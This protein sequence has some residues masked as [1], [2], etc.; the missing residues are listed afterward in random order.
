M[1]E[2]D[3]RF[4]AGVLRALVRA[5]ERSLEDFDAWVFSYERAA[6]RLLLDGVA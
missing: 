1:L 5:V 3:F 2:L 6:E 4:R